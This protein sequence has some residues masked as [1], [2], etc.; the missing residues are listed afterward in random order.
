M[1]F[2]LSEFNKTIRT[3]NKQVI[4]IYIVIRKIFHMHMPLGNWLRIWGLPLETVLQLKKKI[5]AFNVVIFSLPLS[6]MDSAQRKSVSRRGNAS[7]RFAFPP[8]PGHHRGV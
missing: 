5:P 6:N 7:R 3:N 8:C 4:K 2:V 1:G